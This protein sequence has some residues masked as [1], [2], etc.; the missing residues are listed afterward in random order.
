[1]NKGIIQFNLAKNKIAYFRRFDI[2]GKPII[3]NI[4]NFAKSIKEID[5]KNVIKML[6][7]EYGKTNIKNVKFIKEG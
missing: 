5:A 1:M 2:F 7:T 3:T 4:K 6:I